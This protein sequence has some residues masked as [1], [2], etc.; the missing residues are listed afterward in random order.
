[1]SE[2]EIIKPIIYINGFPGVG[3]YTIAQK[4]VKILENSK[5]ID[6]HLL[7]N[8][9]DAIIDR[10]CPDY[11]KIR[12]TIRKSVLDII[13]EN[14]YTFNNIYI[15]TDSQSISDCSVCKEYETAANKRNCIFIPITLTCSIEENLNRIVSQDRSLKGKL[16]SKDIFRSLI[17]EEEPFR[18]DTKYHLEIDITNINSDNCAQIIKNHILNIID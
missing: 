18:F 15:F 5:L 13:S 4:L 2:I 12:K 14:I 8:P 17:E 11:Q 16:T 3:K 10:K 9:V 1:M 6:N 7:I